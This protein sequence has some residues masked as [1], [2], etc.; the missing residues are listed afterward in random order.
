MQDAIDTTTQLENDSEATIELFARFLAFVAKNVNSDPSSSHPRTNILYNAF[1]HFTESYLASQDVHT[2]TSA[3][4]L[5]VRRTVI[6]SYFK[7]LATLESSGITDVPHQPPSALFAAAKDA[8]ASIYAVFGGQGTNEVYFDELQNLYDLYTPYVQPFVQAIT[9]EL[10]LPLVRASS[11]SYDHGLDVSSWLSGSAPRP[12]VSYLA[13]VAVSFPVIG[14]TQLTQYLVAFRVAGLT[15]G[16]MLERFSGATGHSQGVVSAVAISASSTDEQFALNSKKALK[17]LSLAGSRAQIAF[18]VVSLEPSIIA[19]SVEGGEGVPSPMLT[20]VGLNFKDL[21]RHVATTNKYL[22]ENSKL[23]ISL[24]NS[25]KAFVVTGPSRALHG[26]VTALR[27]IRAP[28]GLDQS[29][30]PFSKR[31]PAFLVRFLLVGVPFHSPYLADAVDVLLNDDLK[32]E[33]LWESDELQIPVY[34]TADGEYTSSLLG[35]CSNFVFFLFLPGSDLRNSTS[36]ITRSITEQVFALPLHWTKAIDFPETA[37][38]AIDF[39][40]GGANGVGPIVSRILSGRGVRVVILGEKSKGDELYD[41]NNVKY[42]D[43]WDKKWA[44]RLVKTRY[45]FHLRKPRSVS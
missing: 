5:D 45:I 36:S 22:P 30:I 26:L 6:S 32:G 25:I 15:P 19:D 13:S 43:R 28:S 39:G 1:K 17:W 35:V 14:L 2:L 42:E 9:D 29:K 27:K 7:A 20:V 31:K 12:P 24:H 16:E 44:P 23:C 37:T 8:D 21:E 40:P 34:H 10:F 33:E 11:F 38:H 4:D 3:F 41:S 18:P